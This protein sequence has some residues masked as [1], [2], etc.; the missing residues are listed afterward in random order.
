MLI[1]SGQ[2]TLRIPL[3]VA[4][5]RVDARLP[6]KSRSVYHAYEITRARLAFASDGLVLVDGDFTVEVAGRAAAGHITG[7]ARPVYRD[8]AFYLEDL[9]VTHVD[10]DKLELGS[11][12]VERGRRLFG[13]L[14]TNVTELKDRDVIDRAVALLLRG[15]LWDTPIYQLDETTAK[16]RLARMMLREIR[17]ESDALV[18]VLD[19][20][21]SW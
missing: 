4:Q 10:L 15:F 1:G 5:K 9:E 11:S 14:G 7:R 16:R 20:T 18:A 21:S 6:L 8:H 17:V 13:N 19:R 12:D 2:L 3:A